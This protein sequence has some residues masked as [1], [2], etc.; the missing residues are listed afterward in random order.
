MSIKNKFHTLN[1]KE[2]DEYLN[3]LKESEG[4]LFFLSCFDKSFFYYQSNEIDQLLLSLNKAQW[5]FDN[6]INSFSFFA[7]NQIIQS[8]LIEEIESTNKIENIYCTK[9]DIFSIITEGSSKPNKKLKSITNSYKLLLD[10][11]RLNISSLGSIKDTYDSLLLDCIEAKDIYDGKYFRKEDVSISDGSIDVHVGLSNEENINKAMNEFI[12][13]FNSN[14][15]LYKKM[16]ISHI[17]L[18]IIHP[19]YDG[20]GRLGRFLMSSGI[21]IN[22]NS[23]FSFLISSCIEK[24]KRN[25]Y[26]AFKVATDPLEFGCLNE[27]VKIIAN[28]L[29]NQLTIA[30]KELEIKKEKI[31]NISKV[32]EFTKSENKIYSLLTEASILT[33]FG[34][35]NKEIIQECNVSK[36]T[37][38][39][40]LNKF[41]NLNLL[42]DI[43]IGKLTYH[44]IKEKK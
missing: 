22:S 32:N 30:I 5:K 12:S 35:S 28:I 19:Y 20:N 43:K 10:E 7:K 6:L 39:Y 26:K 11:N 29:V 33:D 31:D 9:H 14:E 25:Y 16:I 41:E 42:E 24:E 2:F 4:T 27:S 37:L 17:L 3:K 40:T 44:K 34:I 8:Y 23:L 38:I 13:L 1:K 15:E 36:R 21:Y 18:E